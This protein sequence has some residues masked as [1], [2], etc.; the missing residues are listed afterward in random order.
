MLS[1]FLGF[2]INNFGD[3]ATEMPYDLNSREFEVGL[4]MS[5]SHMQVNTALPRAGR[6]STTCRCAQCHIRYSPSCHLHAGVYATAATMLQYGQVAV[7]DWFARLWE[8]DLDE[9]HGYVTTGT[10]GGADWGRGQC[11][12]CMGCTSSSTLWG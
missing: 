10:Q 2:S 12:A 8:I 11:L 1:D 6:H 9:Y 5:L 7:L 3:P 4:D